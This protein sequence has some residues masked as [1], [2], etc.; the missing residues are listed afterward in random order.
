[1]KLKIQFLIPFTVFLFSHCSNS[2]C[3][4]PDDL[5]LMVDSANQVYPNYIVVEPEPCDPILIEVRLKSNEVDSSKIREVHGYLYDPARNKGWNSIM[6]FD[7]KGEFRYSQHF[8]GTI[9]LVPHYH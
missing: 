9:S 1:M 2:L 6:I 5:K 4:L 3:P 8:S 7:N